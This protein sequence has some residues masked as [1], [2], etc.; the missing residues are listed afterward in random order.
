MPESQSFHHP[1]PGY[2]VYSIYRGDETFKPFPPSCLST[3]SPRALGYTGT[4]R[5]CPESS[6]QTFVEDGK[7]LP[8]KD[9]EHCT[10]LRWVGLNG[11][12]KVPPL[13]GNA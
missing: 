9:R 10:D 1:T 4:R 8:V 5:G 11:T 6:T 12:D 3:P 13:Q 7:E 2:G